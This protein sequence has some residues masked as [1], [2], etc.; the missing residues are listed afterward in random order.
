MAC[1]LL[2]FTALAWAFIESP[3][4]ATLESSYPERAAHSAAIDAVVTVGMLRGVF[5][6]PTGG[7]DPPYTVEG[8]TYWLQDIG[9]E[10]IVAIVSSL[11]LPIGFAFFA[12]P[13]CSPY[14]LLLFP[15]FRL[16]ALYPAW[17]GQLY[18]GSWH[19]G[20]FLR[21]DFVFLLLFYTSL[22]CP[23]TSSSSR[24]RAQPLSA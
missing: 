2:S 13:G 18:D 14:L 5:W 16:V 8:S 21:N 10:G 12:E 24:P 23:S 17:L 6:H 20:H 22:S 3:S 9:I 19:V 15:L 7:P 4:H 1:L 11:M